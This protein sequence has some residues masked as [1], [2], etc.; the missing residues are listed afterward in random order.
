MKYS[1]SVKKYNELMEE[2]VAF[3]EFIAACHQKPGNLV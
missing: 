1:E 2:N 3:A